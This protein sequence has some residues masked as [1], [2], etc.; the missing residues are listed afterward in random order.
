MCGF[1][2]YTSQD[3]DKMYAFLLDL[4]EA[5]DLAKGYELYFDKWYSSP[6]L[7]QLLMA[8]RTNDFR[9]VRANRKFM[10]FDFLDNLKRYEMKRRSTPTS[11]LCLKWMYI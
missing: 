4:M 5:A 3:R 2:L 11:F 1:W 8:H 9:T 7:F 6:K 10:P